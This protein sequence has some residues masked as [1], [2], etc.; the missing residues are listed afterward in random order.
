MKKA[1]LFAAILLLLVG[2]AFAIAESNHSRIETR[3]VKIELN[4]NETEQK[5]LEEDYKK[6]EGANTGNEQKVQELELKRQQLE[7]EKS[8]LE[9]QLQA[10]AELKASQSKVYAAV[11]PTVPF[12]ERTTGN[13]NCYGVTGAKLQM[14]LKESGC[15][16][17]A[18]NPGGCYGLGQDCNNVLASACPNWRTDFACQDTFWENYMSRRYGT[19]E[20]ALSHW[21]AR[22]PINGR[23][24]GNWW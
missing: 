2:A 12:T 22:V 7:K 1:L 24:V 15:R 16:L 14:Y 4:K 6:L 3:K 11:A 18:T 13:S 23:D 10:K 9:A 20:R 19:W 21:L 17:D 8:D 5:K